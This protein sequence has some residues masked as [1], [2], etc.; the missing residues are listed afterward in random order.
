MCARKRRRV[1]SVGG[2]GDT[3]SSTRVEVDEAFEL[4]GEKSALGYSAVSEVGATSAG[5]TEVA[6]WFST[7]MANDF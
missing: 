6:L 1:D 5:A 7:F 2:L 3:Y 4:E